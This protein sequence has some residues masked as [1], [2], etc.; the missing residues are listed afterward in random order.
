MACAD[1]TGKTLTSPDR[2]R[3]S[4]V[5][6][7]RDAAGLLPECLASAAFADEAVVVD[8]GSSDETR[9]VAARLGARVV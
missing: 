5:V 8:S 2:A 7:A 1:S 4:V 3:L 6:V 9:A